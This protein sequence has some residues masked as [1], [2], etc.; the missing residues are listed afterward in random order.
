M[1]LFKSKDEKME[2][3]MENLELNNLSERDYS[4]LKQALRRDSVANTAS[5]GAT[6]VN[7]E[8]TAAQAALAI[9]EQNWFIIRQLNQ[10][11]EKLDKLLEK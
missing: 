1:G 8:S 4:L 6:G 9:V 3:L 10:L 2:D 11:N 5:A 7:A